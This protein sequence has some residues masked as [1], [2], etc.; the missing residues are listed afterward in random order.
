MEKKR[1]NE[2]CFCGSGKKFKHCHGN[3]ANFP[4]ETL[5]TILFDHEQ[6]LVVGITNDVLL[7]QFHRD[8]PKIAKS[9]DRL[10]EFDLREV[11]TLLS[12][13]MA[14]CYPNK[15]GADSTDK[16]LATT[17]SRLLAYAITTFNASAEL[18]RHGFRRQYGA[19]VRGVIETI[20]T[21][22]MLN[23]D[24]SALEKFHKSNLKSTDSIV[25]AKKAFPQFGPMYGMFS[26]HFVHI[27]KDSTQFE[28]LVP[29]TPEDEA[30][31]FILANLRA[32][33]WLMYATAELVFIEYV[34]EPRYW[35]KSHE[36]RGAFSYSPSEREREWQKQFLLG[37]DEI[38]ERLKNRT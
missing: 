28:A 31:P 38:S 11:S 27:N 20:S 26:N 37:P 18:G 22:L 5:S 19:M 25:Y 9:F 13:V 21:I 10:A 34:A 29:Y 24:T 23:M 14:L 32:V 8:G 4:P 15:M 16:T 2:K 7:K 30:L 36:L 17:S 35:I 1:R 6:Q 3:L 33:V 12:K